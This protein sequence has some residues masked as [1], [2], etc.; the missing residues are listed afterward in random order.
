MMMDGW[1]W[2]YFTMY[3]LQ[4]A[5]IICYSVYFIKTALKYMFFKFGQG[6]CCGW[7]FS[8][9]VCSVAFML[10]IIG[11]LYITKV[12]L[13]YSSVTQVWVPVALLY[14]QIKG[15]TSYWLDSIRKG[16]QSF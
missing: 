5:S 2:F 8:L 10:A 12:R 1:Y 11:I 15:I 7:K 16:F 6:A 9:L 13:D 3:M 14:I 4:I